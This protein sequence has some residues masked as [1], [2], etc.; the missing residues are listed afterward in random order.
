MSQAA[1]QSLLTTLVSDEIA[2]RRF[3]V[4]R[5]AF[6]SEQDLTNEEK[7]AFDQLDLDGLLD[8]NKFLS[9]FSDAELSVGSIYIKD[10]M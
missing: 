6:L 8:T 1:V 2:Q 5:E 9:N 3:V 7:E 10:A 4:N